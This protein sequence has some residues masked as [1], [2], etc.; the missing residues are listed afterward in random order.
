MA[1]HDNGRLIDAFQR[2]IRYLRISI[3]DH[4]NLNCL[5]CQPDRLIPKLS[6]DAVLSYEEILRLAGVGIGL[7]IKKIRITGGEPLVRRGILDFL[8]RLGRLPELEELCLTTNGVVLARYLEPLR[9]AGISRLNI[10]LDT[11]DRQKFHRLTGVDAWERV[12]KAI[13]GAWQAGFAPIKINVVAMRGINED[14]FIDLARLSLDYPFHIRFIEYMPIGRNDLMQGQAPLLTPQ[15][16]AALAPL[17]RLEPLPGA[18]LDGPARRFRLPGAKGEVGFISPISHHFCAS[19][20]RLRLTASGA[21]RPCLLS[22]HQI[23]I[24]TPLR[25]GADDSALA[26]FIVQ[27]ARFK[28]ASHHLAYDGVPVNGQMSA[29]GG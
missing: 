17:G 11:L 15:I 24:K 20:N 29:I 12:W 8:T 18:V 1:D 22:A 25:G 10:S 27:A 28:G 6:H 16:M 4:C 7:G 2:P 9:Q 14:E 23:D 21:L 5:Y 13:M 19:C 3:T 26:G